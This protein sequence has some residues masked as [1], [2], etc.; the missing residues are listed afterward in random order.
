M[1]RQTKQ[2]IGEA[3]GRIP[4]SIYIL[5]SHYEDQTRGML[6]SWVQQVSFDPPM[7]MVAVSKGRSIVPLLHDSHSFALCQIAEHE[8]LMLRKFADPDEEAPFEG[9]GTHRGV[10]GSPILDRA[11]AYLDCQMIRHL[12]IDGD[13]DIYVGLVRDGARLREDDIVVRLRENGFQY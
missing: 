3:L 11:L 9:L 13:H 7:V 10:T 6:V 5:T 8:K 1:D 4:Q 2:R 12:D